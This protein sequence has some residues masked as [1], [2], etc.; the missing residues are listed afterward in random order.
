MHALKVSCT[1]LWFSSCRYDAELRLVCPVCGLLV[2]WLCFVACRGW[3]TEDQ[4]KKRV[5]VN[6]ALFVN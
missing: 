2:Y 5:Q 1:Y 3:V 6:G 4:L